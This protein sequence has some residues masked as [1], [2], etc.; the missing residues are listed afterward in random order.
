MRRNLDEIAP[1]RQL[2]RYVSLLVA[3]KMKPIVKVVLVFVAVIA[4]AVIFVVGSIIY[5][6]AT[7]QSDREIACNVL[8]SSEWSELAP[9]PALKATKQVQDLIILVDGYNR[10]LEDTRNEIPLPDG[11]TAHPEVVLVDPDGRN[12]PLHSSLLVSAGV[13]YTTD[14]LLLRDKSFSKVKI[15]SD[16]PFRASSIIWENENLK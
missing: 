10:T 13:G 9:Q 6:F 8:I 4:L 12:Y 16:K 15:R 2:R 11:T 5:W 1:P 3:R 14:S 7:K